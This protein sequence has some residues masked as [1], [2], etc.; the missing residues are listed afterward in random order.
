MSGGVHYMQVARV[1]RAVERCGRSYFAV[2]NLD[3]GELGMPEARVGRALSQLE[4]IGVIE[5]Y[6]PPPMAVYTMA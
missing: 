3:E 1:H 2:R 4:E 5:Q 6:S